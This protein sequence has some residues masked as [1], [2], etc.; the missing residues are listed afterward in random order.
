MI[1]KLRGGFN[2]DHFF[3]PSAAVTAM[4]GPLSPLSCAT[5]TAIYKIYFEM[6][7]ELEMTTCAKTF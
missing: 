2:K 1:V 7:F 4:P 6:Y 5:V 3:G